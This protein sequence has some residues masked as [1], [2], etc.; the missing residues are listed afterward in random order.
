MIDYLLV[1]TNDKCANIKHDIYDR[2]EALTCNFWEPRAIANRGCNF[3]K[4]AHLDLTDAF[5]GYS[6][7][8]GERF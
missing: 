1:P 4:R 8:G 7:L 3:L 6:I 5:P 2:S